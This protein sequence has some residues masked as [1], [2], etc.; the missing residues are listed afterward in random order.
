MGKWGSAEERSAATGISGSLSAE[1]SFTRR[2]D[3]L[4]RAVNR[5]NVSVANLLK[6]H[7]RRLPPAENLP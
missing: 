1:A 7:D 5:C 6:P 2:I 3:D 4:G